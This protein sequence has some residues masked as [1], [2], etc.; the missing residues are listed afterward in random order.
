MWDDQDGKIQAATYCMTES[1]YRLLTGSGHL[2]ELDL[3]QDATP[4]RLVPKIQSKRSPSSQSDFVSLAMP[5]TECMYIF[6]KDDD[7]M[8]FEVMIGKNAP[9]AKLFQGPPSSDGGGKSRGG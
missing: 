6:R 9:V 7:N 2:W 8:V 1:K 3:S 4:R 5:K